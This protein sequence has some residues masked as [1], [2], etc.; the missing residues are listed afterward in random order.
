MKT[1]TTESPAGPELADLACSAKYA[2]ALLLAREM[3]L[4]L[5]MLCN[6]DI[7]HEQLAEILRLMA[8]A[9]VSPNAQS[10]PHD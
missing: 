9:V 1:N 4:D 6:E 8:E 5:R 2:A 10:Q 7:H 3:A